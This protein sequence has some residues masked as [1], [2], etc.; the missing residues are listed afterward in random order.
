MSTAIEVRDISKQFKL[1]NEKHTSLKERVI[2]GGKMPYTPFW[3]LQ[4]VNV[5]IMQGETF[6]I[7]GRNGCGKSTLLKCIA[8]ILKPTSGEIRVRGSL[9]AM[10]EL[11][12]GFQPD[13]SGRDN[14]FLNGSLLGL[15]HA[16]ME[17]RFDDI[18]AFAELEEF[19]DN[20]VKFYSSGMYVR[21]GFAVAVNVEPDVLLVDEVLA[22]GDASFQRKCLD[23]VKK[24][25]REGRTIVVVSHATD[26]MRQNCGRVMVMNHGKVITVDEPGEGIRVFLADLLGVGTLEGSESGG[27]EGNV[28]AI[29]AVHAEHGGSGDRLHLYP[30]ESLTVT[31]DLDSL[32]PVP[33]AM[34]TIA[35]H[36][37]ANELVFASDPGRPDVRHRGARGRGDRA[38]P[39]PRGAAPRRHLLG[40]RRRAERHG[41][42]HLRLE[43]PGHQIRGGQPGAVHRPGPSAPRHQLPAAGPRPDR[44][45][46]GGER[47]L[48]HGRPPGLGGVDGVTADQ[49]RPGHPD[50]GQPGRHRRSCAAAPRPAAGTRAT[51][52]TST[53]ATPRPTGST[54]ATRSPGSVTGPSAGRVLL[55]QLS[56]GS[57][58]ADIFRERPERKFVNYHNITPADL[59]EA[60]IPAV[61]EEVRWGRAQLRDLAPVTEFAIADSGYNERELRDA[62]YRSTA[63]VPLLIDPEDFTGSPDP[64]LAARLA[65]QRAAGG[66]DLLFVGKVSPH[67]GQHDLVKA[68][69]AYR[70]LVRPAGPAPHRGRGHQRGVPGGRASGSPRNSAWPTPWRWPDR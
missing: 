14:I 11:G 65:G 1:Y 6:G 64:G 17:K 41:D 5:D 66:A 49:D 56:I 29:G 33:N 40:E 9:A 3:A 27:I 43:G 53:T 63:T 38:L 25:Q 28:L 26:V 68:L 55:Y 50:A 47:R 15:S 23:H 48:R 69:A 58:V 4:D 18:V 60:W 57:G 67:K 24:F 20:Q 36:D 52:P 59:L 21:L 34:A 70:R 32:A 62:G 35:I 54:R 42:G 31:A 30:G 44:R 8:G 10:L 2:H 19:I 13:L 7:I 39:L 61:G 46:P 22:V 37:D 16:D 45:G 51:G 12:A